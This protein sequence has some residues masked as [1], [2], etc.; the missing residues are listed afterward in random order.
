MSEYD[1]SDEFEV[2]EDEQIEEVADEVTESTTEE[3]TEK[4][5]TDD[6]ND[7]NDS[8]DYEVWKARALKAEAILKRKQK[9]E[10]QPQRA[11]ETSNETQFLT[12][13][14]GILLARGFDDELLAQAHKI[15]KGAGIS[16]LEA[17]KDPL[18]IAFEEK[19]KAEKKKQKAQ[20]GASNGSGKSA[21]KQAPKDPEEHKKFWKEQMG[22]E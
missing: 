9:K 6:F 5:S 3:S 4:E 17:V 16:L 18:F 10:A 8:D 20:L 21:P 15:A 7:S 22:L 14:E 11:Q 12:R 19:Q 2:V 13:D 1:Q